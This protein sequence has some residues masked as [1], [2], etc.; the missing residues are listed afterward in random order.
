M[1]EESSCECEM[2][3]H[4][5]LNIFQKENKMNISKLN[6]LVVNLNE[7]FSGIG[8]EDLYFKACDLHSIIVKVSDSLGIQFIVEEKPM[9]NDWFE[10]WEPIGF[11]IFVWG[12]YYLG[13]VYESKETHLDIE[14]VLSHIK[15]LDWDDLSAK[16]SDW[17]EDWYAR[18]NPEETW[19]QDVF[20]HVKQFV[21][22][23]R[24]LLTVED[25]YWTESQLLK[26]GGHMSY[27]RD[28]LLKDLFNRKEVYLV[29]IDILA[30]NDF[31]YAES[32]GGKDIVPVNSM[33]K[34]WDFMNR[35]DLKEGE[36]FIQGKKRLAFEGKQLWL[37]IQMLA[38]DPITTVYRGMHMPCQYHRNDVID[39]GIRESF[40]HRIARIKLAR[41]IG[42]RFAGEADLYKS[43]FEALFDIEYKSSIPFFVDKNLWGEVNKN[44]EFWMELLWDETFMDFL[45]QMNIDRVYADEPIFLKGA[46][47]VSA[48]ALATGVYIDELQA[49]CK[50]NGLKNILSGVFA[51]K[52]TVIDVV[53]GSMLPD[54]SIKQGEWELFKLPNK[55]PRNLWIG[56]LIGCC[57]RI[58]GA[59]EG[60]VLDCWT[61][62]DCANYAIRSG[63]GSIYAYF[64]AWISKDGYIC[65][66]SIESRDFVPV[67]IIYGLVRE[68][69]ELCNKDGVNVYISSTSHGVTEEIRK[70]FSTNETISDDDIEDG[71]FYSD[72][73]YLNPAKGGLRYSDARDGLYLAK[74]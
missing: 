27:E 25:I 57:Q 63:S 69:V 20:Y 42:K 58:G 9:F 35:L 70:L 50:E 43:E 64:M 5:F 71:W 17:H 54:L 7:N 68:F 48:I 22:A 44:I 12:Q 65:I 52:N 60:A 19:G 62:E 28:E 45:T 66:D 31:G 56:N 6:T 51:L 49:F 30:D 74:L 72:I 36:L 15:A 29:D 59:G 2:V 34:G 8:R 53:P 23:K 32:Y 61:R 38:T 24:S 21:E 11:Q 10:E 47:I 14:E 13:A 3:L 55:D 37:A 26:V 39:F 41:L 67:N 18:E 33:G 73:C 1:E 16:M 46:D 4:S 40:N